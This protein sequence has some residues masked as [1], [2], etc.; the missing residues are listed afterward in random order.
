MLPPGQKLEELVLRQGHLD[1]F[2]GQ[3][4]AAKALAETTGHWVLTFDVAHH[5]SENLLDPSVQDFLASLVEAA[6]FLS[7]GAGPVCA[8]FSRAVR[9]PV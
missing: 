8:S 4:G 5:A 9:P 1:L 7:V 3:R 6:A 2:S